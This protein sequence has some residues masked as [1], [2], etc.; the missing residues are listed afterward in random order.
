MQCWVK[1]GRVGDQQ[2]TVAFEYL[3]IR[4]MTLR[5]EIY[6]NGF[7]SCHGQAMGE[8][9]GSSCLSHTAFLISNR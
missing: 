9:D 2:G 8:A 7:L 3:G 1:N 6:Q 4:N 5:P